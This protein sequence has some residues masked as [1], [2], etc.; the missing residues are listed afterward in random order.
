M[1][2]YFG[3]GANEY[4]TLNFVSY[5]VFPLLPLP[6][7][8][9][10]VLFGGGGD[11]SLH[12]GGG[13]D[14]SYGGNGNDY[15]FAVH[16]PD[17]ADGGAGT[18]TLVATLANFDYVID[19][20]TGLTQLAFERFIN[21]ENLISGSGNDFLTGTKGANDIQGGDGNDTINGVEGNDSSYGGNGDD[22]IFA[23]KG[24]NV[25]D[26]G[27]GTDTLDITI[28]NSDSKVDLA[29][30]LTNIAGES[31]VNFE[32]LISGDGDDVL[33]GT[34]GANAISG[35][36][37][38]DDIRG[39][40]GD[41]SVFGGNGND[42]VYASLGTDNADGGLGT[43]TLFTTSWTGDYVV[44]LVT[45]LTNFVG[46]S[47]VNFENLY[48][49]AGSD[50]LFGTSGANVISGD[51]GDDTI[52]SGGGADSV[53]GGNGN[54]LVYASFDIDIASGG[55]GTDTLNT[56]TFNGDYVVNLTTGLTNLAGESFD[57]FENL[58]SG[59]GNDR[60]IG[61]ST[62]NAITGGDGYDTINGGGGDDNLFGGI[63]LDKIFGS[64][65]ADRLRGGTGQDILI[66]GK[67]NDIFIFFG[68]DRSNGSNADIIRAGGG[69]IA[70][71]GAGA[72]SGDIINVNAIDADSTIAGN[73][74][75][76]GG[77]AGKG[78]IRVVDIGGNSVVQGNIDNDGAFE[79]SIT[80]EDGGVLALAYTAA[81]FV[82]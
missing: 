44:N 80:I 43:D 73:Q 48:A 9:D 82:F 77:G 23:V 7:S 26:G 69:A 41:D 68:G 56:T 28:K 30:G 25:A 45:G 78:Q 52:Y 51:D 10:D 38:D 47:F 34:S 16:G 31:L 27:G 50:L 3:T 58:I 12:G 59:A 17:F 21:F 14:E 79:I 2:K 75:F 61:T 70:F 37:G 53:G 76:T 60:L 66:G 29:T 20:T 32:N 40:G 35:G 15:I 33:V 39:G 72:G 22:Y 36:D 63:G 19:L 18:D 1:T 64:G 24:I 5:T 4:I 67:G 55:S 54:D 74:D 8:G 81:D 6:N 57:T 11:D 71:E 62:A 49:G 13:A 46:E 42:I 65:G